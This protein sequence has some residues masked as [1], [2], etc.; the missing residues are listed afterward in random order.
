MIMRKTF[1]VPTGTHFR[2]LNEIKDFDWHYD[3]I[4][5]SFNCY[6]KF[7]ID[8]NKL[9]EIDSIFPKNYKAIIL[10]QIYSSK[11]IYF[12]ILQF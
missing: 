11:G 8:G 6:F 1:F 5:N 3:I 4:S 2:K 10:P 7:Y 9:R 12:K